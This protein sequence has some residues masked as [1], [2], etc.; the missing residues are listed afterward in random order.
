MEAA[1]WQWLRK[2]NCTRMTG[3]LAVA[4]WT[5]RLFTFSEALDKIDS[6]GVKYTE[7][8]PNHTI[9]G[10]IGGTMDYHMDKAT[11]QKC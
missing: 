4:A 8:Y 7:G 6:C 3:K 1:N 10:G 5:F 9:G 2:N 11:R